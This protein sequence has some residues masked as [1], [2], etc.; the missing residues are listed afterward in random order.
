MESTGT[1]KAWNPVELKGKDFTVAARKSIKTEAVW[2]P[3]AEQ[4]IQFQPDMLLAT[5]TVSGL[6][7]TNT[8]RQSVQTLDSYAQK[9]PS[10]LVNF[11]R[12]FAER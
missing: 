1:E 7:I 4:F 11:G 12:L 3:Y 6:T 9:N 10:T 5:H 2:R 8:E